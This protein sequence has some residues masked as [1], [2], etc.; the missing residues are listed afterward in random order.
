MEKNWLDFFSFR[1]DG[2]ITYFNDKNKNT[3]NSEKHF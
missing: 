3:A 2:K 1:K